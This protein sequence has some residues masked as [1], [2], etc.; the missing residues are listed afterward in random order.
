MG[1]LVMHLPDGDVLLADKHGRNQYDREHGK[2]HYNKL[3]R[4]ISQA[5][6][7]K[8]EKDNW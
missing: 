7:D 8:H 3:G 2:P 1:W 5:E 4:Y 6:I